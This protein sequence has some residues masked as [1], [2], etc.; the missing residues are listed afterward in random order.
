MNP[1]GIMLIFHRWDV[2]K[3]VPEIDD[4]IAQGSTTLAVPC[5]EM[6]KPF[7][8]LSRSEVCRPW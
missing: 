4:D 1:G 6:M 3:S 7:Q 8:G 5:L 2:L